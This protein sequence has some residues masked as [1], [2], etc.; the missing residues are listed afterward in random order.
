MPFE[1]PGSRLVAGDLA[2]GIRADGSHEVGQVLPTDT[3]QHDLLR[4]GHCII[5]EQRTRRTDPPSRPAGK[6]AAS[7]YEDQRT[8]MAP[9]KSKSRCGLL[10]GRRLAAPLT[11]R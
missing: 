11:L 4:R 6:T 8:T 9:L 1:R 10:L 7:L 5:S 3:V 2:G